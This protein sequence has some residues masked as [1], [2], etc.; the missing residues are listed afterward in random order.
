[1]DKWKWLMQHGLLFAE[2]G[3]GDGG[4]GGG[5]AGTGGEPQAGATQ[6]PTDGL[7]QDRETLVKIIAG[8]RKENGDE[9]IAAKQ[10]AAD[11]AKAS[12]AQEIGKILGLVDE[13]PTLESLAEQIKNLQAPK[14]D[15]KPEEKAPVDNTMA[16]E[17]AI[18]KSAK[19]HGANPAM[20]TDSVSFLA[21]VKDLD[22]TAAD[23]QTKVVEAA[24]EAVTANPTLRAGNGSAS[25]VDHT[26]GSGGQPK[27]SISIESAVGKA[28]GG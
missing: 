15:E 21:K 11:E 3:G 6:E 18:F 5:D 12:M 27:K 7:P 28:L 9:R 19:E 4:G 22:P 1:M 20:L 26:G 25:G 23:F 13:K 2:D 14:P 24:K 10:K 16:V 8:L 17:L